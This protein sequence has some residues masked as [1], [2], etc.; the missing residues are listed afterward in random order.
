MISDWEAVN[1]NEAQETL[2]I[3]HA[4]HLI[5]FILVPIRSDNRDDFTMVKIGINGMSNNTQ[6]SICV[7]W[8]VWFNTIPITLD[9]IFLL[10]LWISSG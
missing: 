1:Q 8:W 2:V 7:W 10:S 6:N 4:N 5:T 9:Q 3:I